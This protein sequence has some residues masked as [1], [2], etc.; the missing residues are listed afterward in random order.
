MLRIIA[1]HGPPTRQQLP[2]LA[3][4]KTIVDQHHHPL[5]LLRT[6]HPPSGLHH[7]LHTGIKIGVVIT[8]TENGGHAPFQLLVH[9]IELRQTQRS[10]KC[11]DQPGTGQ[12]DAFTK[13]PSQHRKAD[14]LAVGVEL[15]EKLLTLRFA[16]ASGL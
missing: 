2:D 7:F 4:A 11:A 16:H 13:G 1:C 12:I 9:R 15:I 8:G 14:P 5:I 10:D 6:D 3:L